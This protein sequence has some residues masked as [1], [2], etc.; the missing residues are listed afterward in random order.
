[1]DPRKELISIQKQCKELGITTRSVAEQ[2]KVHKYYIANA[3]ARLNKN[4]DASVW[5]GPINRMKAII[6]QKRAD[7]DMLALAK[8][9]VKEATPPDTS[10]SVAL[11]SKP[12][13]LF[14]Q[15]EKRLKTMGMEQGKFCKQMNLSTG[16]LWRLRARVTDPKWK[17][18]PKTTKTLQ[19]LAKELDKIEAKQTFN[20]AADH[21]A[22]VEIGTAQGVLPLP[23]VEQRV[24]LPAVGQCIFDDEEVRRLTN[25]NGELPKP[26]PHVET[27]PQ[28]AE[29]LE[30][31]KPTAQEIIK[32]LIVQRLDGMSVVQL[33]L[34]LARI[35]GEE[36]K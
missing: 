28:Y 20:K 29:P 10:I 11:P 27:T 17:F 8:M 2:A 18:Y 14:N 26:V 23:P 3:L 1:M 24:P 30:L 31:H 34:L 19:R 16:Y 4:P 6:A 15:I 21:V 13:D 35:A 22:N 12:I 7:N 32:G 9:K 36:G 33:S 5:G 25:G